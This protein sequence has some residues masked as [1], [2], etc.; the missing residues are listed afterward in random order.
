[1]LGELQKTNFIYILKR[2]YKEKYPFLRAVGIMES[3]AV[4]AI[5]NSERL[6]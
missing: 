4:V 6:T 1:M 3:E 5:L 2:R